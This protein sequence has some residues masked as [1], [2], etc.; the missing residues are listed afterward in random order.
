MKKVLK[1]TKS[2][3]LE[4]MVK[5]NPDFQ[6]K[7]EDKNWIQN[8]V[9][10]NH[11]GYCTPMT[12][13]TCTPKR[14]ALAKRF[15]QGINEGV[16]DYGYDNDDVKQYQIRVEKLKAFMDELIKTQEYEVIDTLYRLL[17]DRKQKRVGTPLIAEDHSPEYRRKMELLKGKI[18]FLYDGNHYDII[19]KINDM[20]G[21]LLPYNDEPETELAE[22][23]TG[24]VYFETLSAA[25]DAVREKVEKRGYTVDEE[26][27]WNYFGTGGIG[28]LQ[29]KRATIP[30][31]KDGIPQRNRS[32]TIAIYRMDSGQYELTSYIN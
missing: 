8:A 9:N 19:D 16:D 5:L 2:L 18:D 25:L 27:M 29:T 23:Q 24:G 32:V 13:A 20:I 15:K 26:D 7:E 28:Y 6:L 3:L 1:D 21:Q 10:P 12:K 11:K 14:K 22:G 30:L 4:N 31:L 17:I